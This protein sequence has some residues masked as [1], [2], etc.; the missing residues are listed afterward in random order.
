MQPSVQQLVD[1]IYESATAHVLARLGMKS[2]TEAEVLNAE[3]ILLQ[4][5]S[6]LRKASSGGQLVR[7]STDILPDVTKLSEEYFG[8]IAAPKDGSTAQPLLDSFAKLEREQELCQTLRDLLEVRRS[9]S[10]SRCCI[11]Q[12]TAHQR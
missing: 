8:I 1:S 2:L 12:L 7:L 9:A 4:I 6:K 10:L 3:A 11:T 5:A